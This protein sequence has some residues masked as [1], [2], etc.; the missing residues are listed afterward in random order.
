MKNFVKVVCKQGRYGVN[1]FVTGQSFG[2]KLLE[3]FLHREFAPHRDLIFHNAMECGMYFLAWK[4]NFL[5]A[6]IALDE[7]DPLEF[8]K[9]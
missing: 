6:M 9:F 7:A 2:D 8:V 3:F 4:A 1:R 5:A